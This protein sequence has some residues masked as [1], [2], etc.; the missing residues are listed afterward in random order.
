MTGS[1]FRFYISFIALIIIISVFSS[2]DSDKGKNGIFK[3]VIYGNPSTLDPQTAVSD[4]SVGIIE[5]MF[6]GLFRF[7]DGGRIIPAMAEEYSVSEN[8]LVWDFKLR[9]DV[10]W[11][12]GKDFSSPCTAHDFVFAFR[13]LMSPSAKSP[14]ASDYYCIKNAERLNK[15]IITDEKMLGVEALGDYELRITLEEP[16]SVFKSLLA[17]SPAMPC[18][19]EFF[20]STEGRYGLDADC[21]AS[22][23]DFYL[24]SWYYDKWSDDTDFIILRRNKLNDNENHDLVSPYGLNY[25][26]DYDGFNAFLNGEIQCYISESKEENQQLKDFRYD[27]YKTSVCG[28]VFNCGGVF[29]NKALRTALGASINRTVFSED[30]SYSKQFIPDNTAIGELNY[31]ENSG[32]VHYESYTMDS[33]KSI[34][35][36]GSSYVGADKINGLKLI[37]PENKEL[38]VEVEYILQ[39]WQ[40][41]FGFY[42]NIVGY[43]DPDYL[44]A[45]QK[46]DFDIAVY[47]FDGG[48]DAVSYINCFSSDSSANYFNINNPKLDHIIKS[49]LVSADDY[50]AAAYCKEAEQLI[51]DSYYFI[52]IKQNILRVYYSDKVSMI[53]F[54]PYSKSFLFR[55]AVIK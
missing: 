32:M 5:N 7:D 37:L 39:M 29:S 21:I 9:K 38:R 23:G 20:N 48:A 13:R 15:G 51:S 55:N 14:N 43:N 17:K 33:L 1:K 50:A 49:A 22:N 16:S 36:E 46:G 3:T 27:E 2:C 44:S 8:G 12:D 47:S 4:S 25:F 28:I 35:E 40:K 6:I 45:L 18:S 54:N 11:Y 30:F 41:E 31:R 26:I 10:M 19:E 42:C 52:P 34:F 24:Y 53:G